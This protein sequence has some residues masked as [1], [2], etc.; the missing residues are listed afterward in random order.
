MQAIYFPIIKGILIAIFM[1][2]AISYLS[3]C[4]LYLS[5]ILKELK[6]QNS[7]PE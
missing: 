3:R 7:G 1:I 4:S 6:K 5:R 2:L